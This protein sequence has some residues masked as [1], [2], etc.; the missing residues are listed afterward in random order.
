MSRAW[1]RPGAICLIHTPEGT[2]VTVSLESDSGTAVLT[3]QDNGPGV[4]EDVAPGVFERFTRADHRRTADT[5]AGLGLS[6][7]AAVSKAHE[8]TVSLESRPGSTT[9]TVRLPMRGGT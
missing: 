8:G 3:V 7:V 5:G 2:Q 6:I 1:R 4:P 9:F